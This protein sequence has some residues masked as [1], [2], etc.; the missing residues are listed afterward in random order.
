MNSLG[1]KFSVVDAVV[2]EYSTIELFGIF[3]AFRSSE[4]LSIDEKGMMISAVSRAS[5]RTKEHKPQHLRIGCII[6]FSD[7]ESIT[8]DG[9]PSC[10]A[11]DDLDFEIVE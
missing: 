1:R 9:G 6:G 5:G 11:T 3:H 2:V 4:I 8:S 10:T 7:S